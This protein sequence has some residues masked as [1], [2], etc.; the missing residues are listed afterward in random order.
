MGNPHDLFRPFKAYQ[1]AV[2]SSAVA[3]AATSFD[4]QTRVVRLVAV[5]GVA[6]NRGI[7]FSLTDSAVT[8][9][10]G[11]YLPGG[12]V[13]LLEVSPSEK[14]FAVGSAATTTLS[15]TEMTN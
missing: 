6:S 8:S 11:T 3:S 12:W 5:D 7:F 13:Q 14:I 15:I 2:G 4:P 1:L 9:L 10:T